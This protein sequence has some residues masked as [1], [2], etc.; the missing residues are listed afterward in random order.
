MAVVGVLLVLTGLL[1][2][3]GLGLFAL[4]FI[5]L[6]VLSFCATSAYNKEIKLRHTLEDK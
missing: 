4:V 6:G 3:A 5:V 2:F 1:C